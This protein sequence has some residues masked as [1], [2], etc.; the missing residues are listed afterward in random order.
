MWASENG[1]AVF[2]EF[3]ES[4]GFEPGLRDVRSRATAGD[5]AQSLIRRA[6]LGLFSGDTSKNF[7]GH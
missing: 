7:K 3:E 4:G 6:F 2:E 1:S 5:F